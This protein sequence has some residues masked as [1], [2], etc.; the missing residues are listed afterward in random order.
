MREI[1]II[2][3]QPKLMLT[4]QEFATVTGLPYS[5]VWEEAATGRLPT[6]QRE[7]GG[8]YRV[9]Y[10]QVAKFLGPEA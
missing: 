8:K 6:E 5:R 10:T 3:G 7:R 2:L 4:L 1:G 9:H